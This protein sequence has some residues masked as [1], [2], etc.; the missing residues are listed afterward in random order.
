MLT[1]EQRQI[2]RM[3]LLD[4]L[5]NPDTKLVGIPHPENIGLARYMRIVEGTLR[6]GYEQVKRNVLFLQNGLPT[7]N[8]QFEGALGAFNKDARSLSIR[9][10]PEKMALKQLASQH[11]FQFY[12][13]MDLQTPTKH[14]MS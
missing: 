3:E 7:P 4:D 14:Y 2:N 10:I 11:E 6:E 13:L 5:F 12:N 1:K 9:S 8:D